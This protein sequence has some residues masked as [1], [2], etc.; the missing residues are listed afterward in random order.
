MRKLT[1]LL[2]ILIATVLISC[3]GYQNIA[4]ITEQVFVG[5]HVDDF[6]RIAKGRYSADAMNSEFYVYRINQYDINGYMIDICS[7]IS[8]QETNLLLGVQQGYTEITKNP[9]FQMG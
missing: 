1:A 3:K 2:F 4:R 5:M 7:I 6:K 8:V 9:P